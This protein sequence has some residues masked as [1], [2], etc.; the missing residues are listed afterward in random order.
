MTAASKAR[1]ARGAVIDGGLR[2][3]MQVL[4]QKFPVF[5]KYRTSNGTLSRC[6]IIAYQ[7]PIKIGKVIIKPRDVIF[8]DIDG[9][10]VIPR[11]IQGVIAAGGTPVEF[12]TIGPCD[13]MT[14]GHIGMRYVLPS[15]DIIVHSIELMAEANQVDGLVLLGGCDKIVPALLMAA[16]RL[17]R[18]AILVNSGPNLP[19][20]VS[21]ANP[22]YQM[23]QDEH[24][25]LSALDYGQGFV[26]SGALSAEELKRVEDT[27]C[28]GG[29]RRTVAGRQGFRPGGRPI[30]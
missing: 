3:T 25:H 1:G 17:D 20:K 22:L 7:A 10:V 18:P 11:D 23:Y 6:K 26:K 12:S 8:G 24:I 2:D 19:G 13:G 28:P 21:V 5:H 15:R 27:V 14:N 4:E 29:E 9:V 30:D 16:A